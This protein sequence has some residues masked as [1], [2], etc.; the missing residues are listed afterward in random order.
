MNPWYKGYTGNI[1]HKDGKI[2]VTGVY[3][4]L[5]QDMLEITELPIGTWTRNYKN[6]LEELDQKEEVDDIR[7]YHQENRVHFVIQVPKLQEIMAEEG[8]ILKKF[9]LQ[10]SMST[11]NFVLFNHKKQ[12]NRYKSEG[13]ILKEWYNLRLDLYHKRKKHQLQ[14]LKKDYEIL[15]NKVRFITGII[16]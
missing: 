6:F 16:N 13:D 11:S 15:K 8:G 12:I 14:K 9:K 1:E 4:V 3:K 10:T 2:Q 7:E 5:G